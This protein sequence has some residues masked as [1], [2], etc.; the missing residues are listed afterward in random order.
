ML[1]LQFMMCI[2]MTTK[3]TEDGVV[4]YKQKQFCD[5]LLFYSSFC[6]ATEV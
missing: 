4:Y 5:A 1:R 2:K 6:S 3:P